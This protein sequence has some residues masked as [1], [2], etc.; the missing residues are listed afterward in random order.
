MK[1]KTFTLLL[2]VA[3]LLLASC[4]RT[5]QGAQSNNPPV[6]ELSWGETDIVAVAF[7]GYCTSFEDFKRTPAFANLKQRYGLPDD[8]LCINRKDEEGEDSSTDNELYLVIPRDPNA[9]VAVNDL[10]SERLIDPDADVYGPILYKS[11]EGTPFFIKCQSSGGMTNAEIIIVDNNKHELTYRPQLSTDDGSLMT[12]GIVGSGEGSVLDITQPLPTSS[13]PRSVECPGYPIMA[14]IAQGRVFLDVQESFGA[15]EDRAYAL[16]G[17]TG[18]CIGLFAGEIGSDK[19][20]FLCLLM[21]DGGVEAFCLNSISGFD[22]NGDADFIS[23][24]RLPDLKDITGFRQEGDAI[25]AVDKSGGKHALRPILLPA[26]YRTLYRYADGKEYKL[27]I[28]PD[29]KLECIVGSIEGGTIEQHFG[30]VFQTKAD[31][32]S[33]QYEFRYIMRSHTTF[34]SGEANPDIVEKTTPS[35]DTGSFRLT[36]KDGGKTYDF[37]LL[38]GP[39]LLDIKRGA[40]VRFTTVPSDNDDSM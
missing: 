13:L 19:L 32:K 17:I 28:Y 6:A 22:P 5:A 26:P 25:Q 1:T 7:V 23:S 14:R 39:V 33:G 12:P 16:E 4:H 38:T 37:I 21:D 9:S 15:V 40:T 29:W 36:T 3:S 27:L 2:I 34:E 20:P 10:P 31:A 11:E 8:V 24:G 30:Q 35:T 18:R